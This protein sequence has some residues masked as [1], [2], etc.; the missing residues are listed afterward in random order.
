MH[1]GKLYPY[2]WEYWAGEAWFWP[3]WLPYQMRLDTPSVI[4]DAW[5][6][7]PTN[8]TIISQPMEPLDDTYQQVSYI[9]AL[10]GPPTFASLTAFL[11]RVKLS[12]TLYAL[13]YVHLKRAG[14]LLKT[15][16]AMQDYPQS[17]VL[18]DWNELRWSF[19]GSCN[20]IPLNIRLQPAA[21]EYSLGPPEP[22]A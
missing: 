10:S 19:P 20:P 8:A 16:V 12:N 2:A 22:E 3:G 4:D 15:A 7:I 6:S 18:C 11:Q 5:A 13:W 9:F 14:T 17:R 21:W 1:K